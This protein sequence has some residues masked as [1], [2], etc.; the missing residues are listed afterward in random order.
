[1]CAWNKKEFNGTKKKNLIGGRFVS[2][3][4]GHSQLN[5]HIFKFFCDGCDVGH[6][7]LSSKVCEDVGLA[8]FL[9]CSTNHLGQSKSDVSGQY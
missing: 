4:S 3:Q 1:M 5:A 8:R 2:L 9:E 7:K 6:V